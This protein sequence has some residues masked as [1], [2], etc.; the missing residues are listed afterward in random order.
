MKSAIKAMLS[1]SSL[2]ATSAVAA[3][4]NYGVNYNWYEVDPQCPMENLI[5]IIPHFSD[6]SVRQ[7]IDNQLKIMKVNGTGVI[8]LLVGIDENYGAGSI[9]PNV[10]YESDGLK[11]QHLNS[12]FSIVNQFANDVA[13]AGIGTLYLKIG[14][15]FGACTADGAVDNSSLQNGIADGEKIIDAMMA[16]VVNNTAGS[17][18]SIRL[19]LGGEIAPSNYEQQCMNDGKVSYIKALWSYYVDNY[20]NQTQIASFSAVADDDPDP[21][22]AGNRL[23]N[24]INAL[25]AS[26]KI[27]PSWFSVHP[28]DV[29]PWG[30]VTT[31]ATLAKMRGVYQVYSD[32]GFLSNQ[33]N[34]KETVVGEI[35]YQDVNSANELDSFISYYDGDKID[36]T[37]II[38]WP[39]HP[40]LPSCTGVANVGPPYKTIVYNNVLSSHLSQ[41][42]LNSSI[43]ADDNPVIIPPGQSTGSTTI[44]WNAGAYD[45]VALWLSYDGGAPQPVGFSSGTNSTTPP[46]IQAGHSYTFLLYPFAN[47]NTETPLLDSVTVYGQ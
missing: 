22:I 39:L 15:W 38:E 6:A 46:W 5:A 17:R 34:P 10:R 14:G 3:V 25:L 42:Q 24:L 37:T 32:F 44:R 35:H 27:L 2:L 43:S 33:S 18:L 47:G 9:F 20:Q 21:E 36:L 23:K 4:T 45:Q 41:Q 28:Y 13:D 26:G 11:I 30:N 40:P 16:Q 12:Y 7:K 19:D 31:G 29:D 8:D 1:M